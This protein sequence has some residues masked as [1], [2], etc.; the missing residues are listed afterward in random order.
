M[1]Y[2]S[3]VELLPQGIAA[4]E[5]DWVAILV[6]FIGIGFMFLLDQILPEKVENPHHIVVTMEEEMEEKSEEKEL[7]K[8]QKISESGK[9]G[10]MKT[11]II[12]ALAIAIHNFPEGLATFGATLSGTSLGVVL[13]IAVAIHNIPEGISVSI[14][15]LYATGNKKKAFWYSFLSGIA[16]PIGAALGYLIIFSFITPQI[17]G[18]MLAFIAGVMVYISLDEILP[19][20]HKYDSRGHLTI[21]GIIVGMI[22]MA[23][24]LILLY[25]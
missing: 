5:E 25:M 14:P 4:V 18:G 3:F 8:N 6:F 1:T 15:I 20:A 23:V 19:T 10:L 12:T 2:V 17:I 21:I 16:E 11:G 9:K 13:A 22:I 7:K 24:S